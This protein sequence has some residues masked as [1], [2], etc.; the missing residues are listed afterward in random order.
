VYRARRLR[1]G[2]TNRSSSH[3]YHCT[4]I[5]TFSQGLTPNFSLMTPPK[6]RD[7]RARPSA[8][9]LLN[10]H[11]G[12]STRGTHSVVL[13]GCPFGYS[14]LIR[15]YSTA[16]LLSRR[17]ITRPPR[18]ALQTAA[19]LNHVIRFGVSCAGSL[20]RQFPDFVVKVN[21]PL[22]TRPSSHPPL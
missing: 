20:V 5:L 14:S 19:L 18:S 17:H 10:H 21:C 16:L 22:D 8:V 1:S 11:H 6:G 12:C 3:N 2:G 4:T 15:L 9:P 13:V 7:N